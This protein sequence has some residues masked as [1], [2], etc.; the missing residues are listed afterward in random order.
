MNPEITPLPGSPDERPTKIGLLLRMLVYC[1]VAYLAVKVLAFIFYFVTDSLISS[2]LAVFG[3]A[4]LA[5]AFTL[6]IFER[7]SARDIG[8]NW[9]LGALRNFGI[10]VVAAAAAGAFT[11]LAPA[12]VGMATWEPTS[13]PTVSWSGLV[14]TMVLLGLGVF[15]EE[16]FF[17]GYGFQVALPALGKFGTLLPMGVLFALAHQDNLNVSKLAL[18]NTFAWGV[19]L[20]WAVLR[21]GD[22]WLATGLHAGWN[23]TL[24]LLGVNLSGFTMKMTGFDVRWRLAEVWSGGGYGPEGGLLCTAVI[25]LLVVALWRAPLRPQTL[26]LLREVKSISEGGP[27]T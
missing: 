26:T 1:A 22:L 27:A 9:G 18:F 3:A 7:G 23:W 10:G 4:A 15:G 6:R 25:V 16:L 14:Y 21:S 11:V 13:L 20:G 8:L 19:L 5:N 2:V 12:A 24:P 17:R